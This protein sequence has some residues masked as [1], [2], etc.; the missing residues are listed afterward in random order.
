MSLSALTVWEA[1]TTG[2]SAN[3]GGFVG[4]GAGTDYS[5]QDSPEVTYDGSTLALTAAGAGSTLSCPGRPFVSADIDNTLNVTG[6]TNLTTGRYRILSVN[7]SGV[8][9]LDRAVSTGVSSNGT[10]RLGGALASLQGALTA[11]VANNVIWVKGTGHTITAAITGGQGGAADAPA[12]ILGYVT[13]RGDNELAVIT[14]TSGSVTS[15]LTPSGSHWVIRNLKL[16]AGGFAERCYHPASTGLTIF[17]ENVWAVGWTRRGIST[18]TSNN[19]VVVNCRA[20]GGTGGSNLES[21]SCAGFVGGGFSTFER[22]VTYNSDSCGFCG[23]NAAP[24]FIHCAAYNLNAESGAG[25]HGYYTFGSTGG[26][27]INCTFADLEGSGVWNANVSASG[28]ADVW[29]E[30]CLFA[31]VDRYGI[32]SV[33]IEFDGTNHTEGYKRRLQNNAFYNCTLGN[34]DGNFPA[35]VN[36]VSLTADPFM[37]LSTGDL[38]LNA[39]SGGGALCREAGIPGALPGL[40]DSVGF[41]DIG[42]LQGGASGVAGS[43]HQEMIDLWREWTGEFSTTRM[44]NAAVNKYLQSGLVELNRILG[45]AFADGTITLVAGTQ[46]YSQP[47]GTVEIVFV[48]H[49]G[50]RLEKADLEEWERTNKEWRTLPA[51]TPKFWAHYGDKVVF[52]PK[53]DDGAVAAA[54]TATV[55]FLRSPRD[56]ATYGPEG[57]AAADYRTAVRWGV[58]EFSEAHPDS[59]AAQVRRQGFEATFNQAAAGAVEYYTRRRLAPGPP[60]ELLLASGIKRGKG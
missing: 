7:G 26:R 40:T 29:I 31:E 42:A 59:A 41:Q 14:M 4:G 18:N 55:R 27:L 44:P 33:A 12:Q 11:M 20:S 51:G 24:Q 2:N 43:A 16:D 35:S 56:I 32:E 5:Q 46:E 3:G 48:E 28:F 38:R 36:E 37:S 30:N 15:M 6:G 22:C 23:D 58:R 10:G 45:Y 8:A 57:L 49:N 54:S 52:I 17:L 53:P 50:K 39:A 1:R 19:V 13:E 21:S 47:E 34:H 60:S 25:G 9:T